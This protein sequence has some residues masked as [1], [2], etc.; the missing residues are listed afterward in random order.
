[1]KITVACRFF[2][3]FLLEFYTTLYNYLIYLKIIILNNIN[4]IIEW[5]EEQLMKL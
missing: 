2:V 5:I 1:M 4:N 3:I